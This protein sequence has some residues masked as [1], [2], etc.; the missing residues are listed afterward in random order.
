MA[1]FL[2]RA[3]VVTAVLL[4]AGCTTSD[5]D[6]PI[7]QHLR[8]INFEPP[9]QRPDYDP[10]RVSGST[11]SPASRRPAGDIGPQIFYGDGGVGR[12]GPAI[13]PAQ[14]ARRT[15]E[16]VEV[17]FDRA[18]I[19][20][21]AR[22]I[23]GD[24]LQLPYTVDP[25]VQ[26]EVTL[27]SAGPLPEEDLLPMV[28]T[29]LRSSN[30]AIVHSGG[31]YAILPLEEVRGAADVTPLGGPDMRV[32][33]GFG[34]T[35]VPLRYISAQN[36]A[37]LIQPLVPRADDIRVD[38]A[39]N[40][41]LFS[42]SSPER[43]NV[44]DTLA[45][46]DVSWL[47]DKAIGIFPLT[48]STPEATIPELEALF[49]ASEV[50]AGGTALVRF[51]PVARLN[52]V[53]AIANTRDQIREIQ[54]WV[55]RLDRGET[56]TT[57]FYVYFLRHAPA[58][59]IARLLNET[60]G[61]RDTTTTGT[62]G[63]GTTG[64]P[65]ANAL[66]TRPGGDTG[67]GETTTGD[68]TGGTSTSP[69][70]FGQ[71]GDTATDLDS[72][73]DDNPR[74]VK[75]V[76]NRNNNSLL[77]R[78]TPDVYE[79]IEATLRRLDTPPLQ[80]LI[81][82][83]IAEVT[84]NDFLRYGIQYFLEFGSVRFGFNDSGPTGTTGQ[85][86]LTPLGRIPGFNF[87]ATPGD[88]NVTIDALAQLTSVKVLSSP[89]VVVQDNSA[90][91]LTVGDEVPVITR[92]A[93]G[94]TDPDSPVVNNVEYRDTGVILEVRPRINTN[95]TVSIDIA[96]E[97]S[98]VAPSSAGSDPL[99]PTFTQ[100]KITSRVNIRSGQTVALGGLI[101]D[102]EERGRNRIP[103]LGDI[104][105]VGNLF[106]STSN[107]TQRTELIVFITPKVIRDALDARDVSEELRSRLKSLQPA[108]PED[109]PW[110]GSPRTGPAV[111]PS[112]RNA[113]LPEPRPLT[114][115]R[116]SLDAGPSLALDSATAVS[117]IGPPVV[118][119]TMPLAREEDILVPIRRPSTMFAAI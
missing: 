2:L 57:Q 65:F 79:S 26:G 80:V 42:G 118:R 39:G 115:T 20:E 49:S 56:Q 18:E 76:A 58:E 91:V 114:P 59:D 104:P 109:G 45:D 90:A 117:A 110:L 55:T 96:Q 111:P 43:Q 25:R 32:N 22:V 67:D 41:V 112:P 116:Y 15:A 9:A 19:R 106:G 75:I 23:L 82:A 71:N 8:S 1:R 52:A 48:Y 53:L 36:A 38:I 69:V 21:V 62:T 103:L 4:M 40:L 17:N 107:E 11:S 88:A 51:L 70:P 5:Q 93:Q 86:G 87:I 46:L 24:I 47:A 102:S 7:L 66:G 37:A 28:E 100:R 97:V 6:S 33:P 73:G 108:Q 92:Q 44:V 31:T 30:A 81:E 29:V 3:G 13:S 83:T 68:T 34:L 78:A 119:P 101:Q 74:S 99:T 35:I 63:T 89:S 60:F 27:S 105:V 77:I 98:R 10:N 64:S 16:G 95:Q 12:G 54:D 50:Q 72:G 85:N 84:L 14:Q 113:P 61:T 94:V